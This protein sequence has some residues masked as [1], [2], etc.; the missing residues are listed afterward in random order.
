MDS[1]KQYE[2]LSLPQPYSVLQPHSIPQT[3]WNLP[4]MQQGP[5]IPPA[6]NRRDLQPGH[7]YNHLKYLKVILKDIR[8]HD[9]SV[10]NGL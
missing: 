9:V 3:S 6:P 8:L 5:V 10:R 1:Y 4:E 2:S 7:R